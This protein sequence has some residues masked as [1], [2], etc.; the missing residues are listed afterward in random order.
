MSTLMQLAESGDFS[1]D[2]FARRLDS[3]KE[4][5]AKIPSNRSS[6][7]AAP[8]LTHEKVF[9]NSSLLQEKDAE[10]ARLRSEAAA[11]Q[12][13]VAQLLQHQEE[14]NRKLAEVAAAHAEASRR[15]A[16]LAAQLAAEAAHKE[17]A[18]QASSTVSEPAPTPESVASA[19]SEVLPSPLPTSET[20]TI[21]AAEPPTAPVEA[22]NKL[23]APAASGGILSYLGW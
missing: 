13:H 5:E 18:L 16:E 1:K 11:A 4:A 8:P 21:T 20:T 19:T 14:T 15:A 7:G 17:E 10:T 2:V 3:F 6:P 12:A 23:T 9:V 22:S